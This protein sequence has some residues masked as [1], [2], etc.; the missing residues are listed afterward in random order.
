MTRTDTPTLR[1]ISSADAERLRRL[2]HRLTPETRYL[3]FFSPIQHLEDRMLRH[4]AG[5]DHHDRE[6]LA[7]VVGD[8]VV[9]V[10]R[11]DR[12]P[13]EPHAAEMAVVV[14][15]RWQRRGIATLL[16]ARLADL[17][18]SR[19]IRRFTAVVLPDNGALVALVRSLWPHARWRWEDGYRHLD[20]DLGPTLETP[21]P[22][23][24]RRAC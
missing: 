15:D 24:G 1:P 17:A 20:V 7:A 19:E 12:V 16:L 6:A 23:S 4:L 13:S 22:T 9:G 8:E 11:Y 5:V 21:L 10:A 18:R 3:R 2:F 14:E